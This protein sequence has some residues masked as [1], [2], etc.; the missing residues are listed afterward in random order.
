LNNEGRTGVVD[1][2]HL[3]VG[4]E[5]AGKLELTYPLHPALKRAYDLL[6]KKF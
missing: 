1:Y 6:Y 2:V 3:G 5:L 4:N